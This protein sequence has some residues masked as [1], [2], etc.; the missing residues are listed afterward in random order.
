MKLKLIF[1][2]RFYFKDDKLNKITGWANL[3]TLNFKTETAKF[4]LARI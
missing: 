3:P 4:F 1:A 2:K